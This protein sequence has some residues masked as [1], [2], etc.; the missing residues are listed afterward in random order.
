M[1]ITTDQAYDHQLMSV[2][3]LAETSKMEDIRSFVRKLRLST[4][5]KLFSYRF[6][7]DLTVANPNFKLQRTRLHKFQPE[8]I[9]LTRPD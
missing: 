4:L 2:V 9:S 5:L 3:I 1:K 8:D 7:I 6:Q